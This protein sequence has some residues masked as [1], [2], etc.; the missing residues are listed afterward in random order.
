MP[1]AIRESSSNCHHFFGNIGVFDL[2]R[3]GGHI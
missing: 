1:I 2:I 3:Q